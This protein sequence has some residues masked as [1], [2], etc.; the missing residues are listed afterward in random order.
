M[1]TRQR[2][3]ACSRK[4]APQSSPKMQVAGVDSDAAR[5]DHNHDSWD[6]EEDTLELAGRRHPAVPVEV[7]LKQRNPQDPDHERGGRPAVTR[8]TS[9]PVDF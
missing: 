7:L 2:Q 8:D 9:C 6:P 5:Q 1:P 4:G 3:R